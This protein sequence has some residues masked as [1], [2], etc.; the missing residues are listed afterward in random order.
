MNQ[1]P[2]LCKRGRLIVGPTMIWRIAPIHYFYR[3]QFRLKRYRSR[4]LR[5]HLRAISEPTALLEQNVAARA[6]TFNIKDTIS[7]IME[8]K[9]ICSKICYF[10]NII[11]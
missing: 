8:D 4:T 9:H 3:D 7:E 10:T 11:L 5:S 1:A 2:L 6:V